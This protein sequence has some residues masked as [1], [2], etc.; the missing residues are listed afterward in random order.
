[1]SSVRFLFMKLSR[2]SLK[3]ANVTSMQGTVVE[4][5][6]LHAGSYRRRTIH[7]NKSSPVPQALLLLS[8]SMNTPPCHPACFSFLCAENRS[9]PHWARARIIHFL[10]PGSRLS[11][12]KLNMKLTQLSKVFLLC[13]TLRSSA[14]TVVDSSLFSHV[15][16]YMASFSIRIG[17]VGR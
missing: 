6:R 17:K 5:Y 11:R 9:T 15:A 4:I 7:I 8:M 10:L 14:L 2:R 16:I 3:L 1:M 13:E 12:R